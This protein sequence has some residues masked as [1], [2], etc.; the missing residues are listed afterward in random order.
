MTATATW[1]ITIM[2]PCSCDEGHAES[3]I[4]RF[5]RV[6][7]SIIQ[8]SRKRNGQI[9]LRAAIYH[10]NRTRNGWNLWLESRD[11]QNRVQIGAMQRRD[12]GPPAGEHL[13]DRRVKRG[14]VG[15]GAT[16]RARRRRDGRVSCARRT[17]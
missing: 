3:I 2:W 17:G 12:S 16:R 4:A 11:E 15:G 5:H 8:K 6:C 9:H 14:S 1:R 13:G 10:R 7:H